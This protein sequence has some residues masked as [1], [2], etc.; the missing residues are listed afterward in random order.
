MSVG[1]QNAARAP[2]API[3]V[4]RQAFLEAMRQ[5]ASAVTIVTTEG[6]SGRHGA[7]VSAFSSVSADPPTVLVCLRTDSRIAAG[8]VGN[9]VFCVNVL[10]ESQE[11]LARR[12]A[13]QFDATAP[14]RFAGVDLTEDAGF[15]PGVVG[16]TRLSCHLVRSVAHRSHMI[17]LGEVADVAYAQEPPLTYHDGGFRRLCAKS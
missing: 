4:D 12:F 17:C 9:G 7:T 16:A 5:V 11:H 2:E 15:G 1:V 14:D 13:G 3:R 10:P 6:A 8:V